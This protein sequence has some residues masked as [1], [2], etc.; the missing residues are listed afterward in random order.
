MKKILFPALLLLS[1]NYS[2]QTVDRSVKP[3]PEKAQ[4]INIGK[5]EVFT[6][7]NGITVI[8][9]ENHKLP[10]VSFDLTMGSSPRIEGD[11]AGLA[12]MA[13]SLIMSGTS[14]R[15]KDQLDKEIDYIG[16]ELNA[17]SKSI[18]LSCLSKHVNT[19][20]DLM[21]D[22][23]LNAN[24][25]ESE[26]ERI[27][28]QNESNLLSAK[29][30]AGTMAQNA[31]VKANFPNHPYSNVMTEASLNA[32]KREDVMNFYKANFTPKGAYMVVVG[33]ITR[34]QTEELLNRY[35]ASWTGAP[36]YVNPTNDGQFDK[37][38]RVI[39]V[40]K[41]GAVQSVVYVSFP[42][43][44]RTGD[45]NQ[46]ALTV[47][48]GILGGGGFGTRLMQNLREDKAYTYGCY[49]SLNITE[50]GSWLSAG[51]NFRN[52][53]TDSAI[54]QILKELDKITTEYVTDEEISLTKASM[55][56]NFARSL[57]RPSTL[58]RF[59]L[60][61]KKFNLPSDYYQTYLQR[62]EAVSKEDVL[63]MAQQYFTAK[64][65]HIVVVGNEEI[66]PKLKQF[67][68][69]GKIEMLDAFG[70]PVKETIK[71]DITK[72]EL[73]KR[74]AYAMLQANNEKDFL[75]KMKKIKSHERVTDLSSPMIPIPLKLT[76]I[77]MAPSTE[78]QKMEGQG[79]MIQKS[80]YDG[81]VGFT[82]NMQEGKKD[83]T[84]EE[85]VSKKKNSSLIPEFDYVKNGVNYELMGIEEIE[86]TAYYVV[87]VK[88]DEG[89]SFDFYNTK[90]FMKERS[91]AVR[92]QGEESTET[93]TVLSDFKFVDGM[94]FAHK[95]SLTVGKMSLSGTVSKV[96]VNGKPDLK[97]FK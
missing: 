63:A 27:R 96:T 8:L 6:T 23:L 31:V 72:E 7:A 47:L 20:L 18:T 2:A 79:M 74:Y 22:V 81:K 64:N 92:K 34:A 1:L 29:S 57:E 38:N 71:A 30:D 9:S 75:K 43:K 41:P 14:K 15:G 42:V 87:K 17:D 88:D 95:I 33:D 39:F 5:S 56:G 44:M 83:L 40:K 32:I 54:T 36:A 49:S 3:S 16:A 59:A 45:K 78:A 58:A 46:L 35:F 37:G 19:G 94:M 76:D 86:G 13:G 66:L 80:F 65:C 55:A 24:F 77:W 67:D 97:D 52:A 21:S 70:N 50:D 62:L 89:E 85:L 73:I 25:P 26:F 51:G 91:T 82:F 61:I 60:N 53:V 90:T 48:N 10:K 12:D 68:A 11:K 4:P 69:D 93:S 84:A 28:K